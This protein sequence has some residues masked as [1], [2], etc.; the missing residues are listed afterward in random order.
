M[1]SALY[2]AGNSV[3]REIMDRALQSLGFKIVVLPDCMAAA[4]EQLR[5]GKFDIVF[6]DERINSPGDGLELAEVCR[7]LGKNAVV[8][9][10]YEGTPTSGLPTIYKN[11]PGDLPDKIRKYLIDYNIVDEPLVLKIPKH[12]I[13]LEEIEK[14]AV[15]QALRICGWIQ[16]DAAAL[17]SISPRVMCYKVKTLGI[18]VP[19]LREVKAPVS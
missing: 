18:D 16:K 11:T 6:V 1:L 7:S 17:L 4:L 3:N 14:E 2:L 5:I 19:K 8:I 13:P 15:I 12:G 9:A 10:S